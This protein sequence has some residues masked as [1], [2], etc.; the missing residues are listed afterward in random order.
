MMEQ[1]AAQKAPA[2]ESAPAPSPASGRYV[3]PARRAAQRSVECMF[4]LFW[5]FL[6]LFLFLFHFCISFSLILIF[7]IKKRMRVLL[8]VSRIWLSRLAIVLFVTCS[9]LVV[10]ASEYVFPSITRRARA[11]VLVLSLTDQSRGV[12]G[13]YKK[14]GGSPACYRDVLRL[15][16]GALYSVCVNC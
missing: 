8:S 15:C 9:V 14:Q 10:I 16:P 12:G 13:K 6:F 7:Q 2:Q 1:A 4:M 3:P 11:V 5:Y